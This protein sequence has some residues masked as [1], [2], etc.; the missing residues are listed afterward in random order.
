M[1]APQTKRWAAALLTATVLIAVV[2]GAAALLSTGRNVP[3]LGSSPGPTISPDGDWRVAQ[4]GSSQGVHW[5]FYLADAKPSGVCASLEFAPSPS[6]DVSTPSPIQYQ[7]RDAACVTRPQS[8]SSDLLPP[9][10]LVKAIQ[11]T[12]ARYNVLA[13]IAASTVETLTL[14]LKGSTGVQVPIV[15]G[16]FVFVYQSSA[17]ILNIRASG[18]DGENLTECNVLAIQPPSGGLDLR[19]QRPLS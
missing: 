1:V 3:H 10:Q 5:S 13:G 9:I 14:T 11:S 8:S 12:G 17:G 4:V 6:D 18:P 19:C 7:G 2:A 16:T 15:D